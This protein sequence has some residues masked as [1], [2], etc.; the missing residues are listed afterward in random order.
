[1]RPHGIVKLYAHGKLIW[2]RQN[3]FVNTGLPPL[4]NLIAGITAG[5]S[6]SAMGFGSGAAAPTTA[7]ASF[8]RIRSEAPH[9]SRIAS[10][11]M[12]MYMYRSA[13]AC[14]PT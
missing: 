2:Q 3:L 12:G 8:R 10:P 13:R 6:V 14:A 5:Q 11:V 9:A 4:A 7:K 1:M